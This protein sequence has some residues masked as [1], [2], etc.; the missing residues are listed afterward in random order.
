MPTRERLVLKGLLKSAEQIV[1][2]EYDVIV[3]HFSCSLRSSSEIL[4]TFTAYVIFEIINLAFEA[5]VQTLRQIF[6]CSSVNGRVLNSAVLTL[7]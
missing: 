3:P 6:V 7:S 2:Y 5:T 1:K 4:R